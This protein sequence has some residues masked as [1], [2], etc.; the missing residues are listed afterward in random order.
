MARYSMETFEAIFC[1]RC[2]SIAWLQT[3]KKWFERLILHIRSKNSEDSVR[4][5]LHYSRVL[6]SWPGSCT[7]QMH[8]SNIAEGYSLCQAISGKKQPKKLEIKKNHVAPVITWTKKSN[9]KMRKI[10]VNFK[11]SI[12][13]RNMESG[14]N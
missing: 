7:E 5:G 2:H 14:R 9:K 1:K 4:D 11:S 13:R 8:Q 10:T 3:S 6:S 12:H